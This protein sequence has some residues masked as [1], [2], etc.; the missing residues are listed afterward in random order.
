MITLTTDFGQEGGFPS[1]LKGVILSINP[2]VY[3]VDITHSIQPQDV[4]EASF[5]LLVNYGYFPKNTI[6]VAVVDPGVGSERKILCAK[7][8]RGIFVGPDNGLF[9]PILENEANAAVYEISNSKVFLPQ[10]SRTFHGRDKMA[11]AAAHISK[12]FPLEKLGPRL[13]DWKKLLWPKPI[14]EAGHI[15]GKVISIDRFGNLI[16]N[17]T[18]DDTKRIDKVSQV[19]VRIKGRSIPRMAHFFSEVP[20]G[21]LLAIVG[22]SNFVEIAANRSS[23]VRVLNAKVGEEVIIQ[24]AEISK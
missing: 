7:T 17:I 21:E 4:F 18:G 1:A 22:S 14:F 19:A 2:H 15:K 11:P 24:K 12:G 8:P 5:T 20:P 23:A 3:F 16:T 9:S 10:I 13:V 6:H